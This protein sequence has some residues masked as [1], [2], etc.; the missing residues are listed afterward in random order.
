MKFRKQREAITKGK[1]FFHCGDAPR[2]AS[3]HN[4]IPCLQTWEDVKN[5][6]LTEE[7]SVVFQM[8]DL[9]FHFKLSFVHARDMSAQNE[10]RDF[11]VR[12]IRFHGEFTAGLANGETDRLFPLR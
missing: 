10:L 5:S 4:G 9:L 8:E 12:H 11:T 3:H 2:D 7:I 1:I 6:I